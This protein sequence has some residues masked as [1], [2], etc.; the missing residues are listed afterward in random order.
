MPLLEVR[1]LRASYNDAVEVLHRITLQIEKGELVALIGS[2]GAGKTTTLKAI[3]GMART[4]AGQIN[5][6]GESIVGRETP[7]IA[8]RGLSMVPEG[9]GVFPGLSIYD[10]LRIAATPWIK[11]G[12]TLDR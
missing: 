7:D 8:T 4:T 1:D 5:F 9:R 2:N 6:L 3:M 10:N 12:D 11:R